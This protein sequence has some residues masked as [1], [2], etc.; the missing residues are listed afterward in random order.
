MSLTGTLGTMPLPDLL[1]FLHHARKTGTLVVHGGRY[2]KRLVLEEGVIISTSSDD[3]TDYLGQYLLREGR[4]TESQLRKAM[5]VQQKSRVMLG[6]ILV[7]AGAI[8][9]NDLTAL[10][11]AK[12]EETIYSLFLLKDARFEFIEGQMV[13]EIAVRLSLNIEDVLLKGLAW[14]DELQSFRKEFGTSRT[15]LSRTGKETPA[16]FQ[17][18]SS[19]GRRIFDLVDGRRCI[20]DICLESHASEFVVSRILHL[21]YRNGY[22]TVHRRVAA[23]AVVSEKSY[24]EIL[25]EAA[26][27]LRVGHPEEAIKML[28]RARALSPHDIA[29]RELWEKANAAFRQ[30][31][32]RSSVPL[33]SVP[34]LTRPL[35]SITDMAIS[36]EEGFILS[37]VDGSW[38]VQSIVS[39]CPFPETE[40]LLHLKSLKDRNLLVLR[41]PS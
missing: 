24:S 7:M 17:K 8:A 5:E 20:A 29:L 2:S 19:L 14:Y 27:F 4:I 9:E 41:N 38:N 40:A 22:V 32:A 26:S 13:E 36:P 11:V 12:A 21:M 39:L 6:K 16:V 3:P 18:G 25:E 23:S 35:E 33:D 28:E 15:I 34:S 1:Q 10:L 31:I 37:R 30:E